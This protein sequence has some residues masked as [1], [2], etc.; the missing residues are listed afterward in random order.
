MRGWDGG[1]DVDRRGQTYVIPL[2]QTY[3]RTVVVGDPL[4]QT[5]TW[6]NLRQPSGPDV[7]PYAAMAGQAALRSA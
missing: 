3:H 4:A 7:P 2:G 6:K 1:T 5:A